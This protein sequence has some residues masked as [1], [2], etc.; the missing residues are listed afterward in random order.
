ME[1][2]I[3]K[4]DEYRTLC[5]NLQFRLLLIVDEGPRNSRCAS[6]RLLALRRW[7][8]P[9]RAVLDPVA[10]LATLEATVVRRHFARLVGPTDLLIAEKGR[11]RGLAKEGA[12]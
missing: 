1:R 12:A 6:H 11:R 5:T 10:L 2:I 7:D 8:I 3:S 4:F 9:H